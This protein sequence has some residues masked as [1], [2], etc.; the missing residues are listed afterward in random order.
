[1]LAS[2]KLTNRT[3]NV[4]ISVILVSHRNE[5]LLLHRVKTSS[6]F[7]S[8]HVFPGGNVSKDDGNIPAPTEDAR[9]R[10]STT[11][12]MAAI[13]EC[14]EESGI[15][16]AKK[17]G[18]QSLLQV[19]ERDR[20]NARHAIHEGKL[21]FQAWV[22][23]MGGSPDLDGL[24][25]FTRWV[26]PTNVPKRFTT[27]MYLYFLP[28]EDPVAATSSLGELSSQESIIPVPTS[29]GGIEHT[30]ARF[31]PAS[32]W[33]SMAKANDIILFPPQLFLLRLVSLAFE[34]SSADEGDPAT[35]KLLQRQRLQDF[36]QTGDPPWTE[37]CISPTGRFKAKDNKDGRVVLELDKPGPELKASGRRGDTEHVI[38][39]RFTK[40]GPRDVEVCMKREI[41][42]ERSRRHSE[43]TNSRQK[44]SL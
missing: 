24:T 2:M 7:P 41:M 36:I 33:L 19:E 14:F 11:Y 18:S 42:E 10:D 31:L 5:I 23:Q 13:R 34:T 40:D 22:D 17:K 20:E 28:L 1:M 3:A 9:H 16:L 29:D 35:A 39:V 8:A 38:L 37:K 15:L 32:T 43:K 25:P 30:A 26:T 4:E 6:S 12:R 27:Q 21:N 44:G